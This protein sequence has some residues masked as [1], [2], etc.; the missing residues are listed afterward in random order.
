MAD[1][2]APRCAYRWCQNEHTDPDDRD[3]HFEDFAVNHIVS[4][5]LTLV[6]GDERSRD[7]TAHIDPA[8]VTNPIDADTIVELRDG[9]TSLVRFYNSLSAGRGLVF[10]P[11]LRRNVGWSDE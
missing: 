8:A 4:G 11:T 6:D 7:M 5:R 3:R 2:E 10:M 9:L 1:K